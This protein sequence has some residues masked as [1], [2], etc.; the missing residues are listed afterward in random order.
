MMQT[1]SKQARQ[2]FVIPAVVT[3]H[4]PHRPPLSSAP[5]R[6]HGGKHPAIPTGVVMGK[7]RGEVKCYRD[8]QELQ[9]L[10]VGGGNSG[11]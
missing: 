2:R 4:H 11:K 10:G 7:K 8:L 9:P 6:Q 1:S 5:A 3:M